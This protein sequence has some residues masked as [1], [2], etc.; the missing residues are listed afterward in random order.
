MLLGVEIEQP[1]PVAAEYG[2]R[3]DHLG[4]EERV[5]GEAAQEVAAVAVGPVHHG[6]N[7]YLSGYRLTWSIGHFRQLSAS[8]EPRRN[9]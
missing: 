5:G 3:G 6:R 9:D 7:R 8:S 4:V 2:G 1:G